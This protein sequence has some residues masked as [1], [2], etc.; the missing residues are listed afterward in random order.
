MSRG[1]KLLQSRHFRAALS[2]A[3]DPTY[4]S[5]ANIHIDPS[6]QLFTTV[7]TLPRTAGKSPQLANIA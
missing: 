2:Q 1:L 4:H 7:G 6:P 5:I 3:S